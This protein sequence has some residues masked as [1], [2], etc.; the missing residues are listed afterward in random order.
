MTEL[1]WN[2]S[3]NAKSVRGIDL[4]SSFKQLHSRNLTK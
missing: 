4:S 3:G 2:P 1:W